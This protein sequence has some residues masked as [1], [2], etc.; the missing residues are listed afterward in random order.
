MVYTIG[1][2]CQ[3]EE[4]QKFPQG[5]AIGTATS[6]YQI[7]GA[8][9]ISDKGEN[10]W[11]HFTH[12]VDSIVH[13][14]STGDVAC[15]SYNLYKEDVK[16][17]K[18]IG[19]DFYR[20]SISWGRILPN[21]FPN[22]VS[23]EGL[24]YYH[25]LLDELIAKGI[26]PYVTLYHWD[27]PQT[28][29]KLGGWTNELMVQWFTDYARIV[30]RELGPKIKIFYTVNEPY[31]FCGYGYGST[32]LAPGTNM[33][34][35]ASYLCGHNVLKAH[36]SA[37]HLYNEEF[38][39][40]Q[41]GT[42]GIVNI[43]NSYISKTNDTKLE[44]DAFQFTCGWFSHP[45]FSKT[46]DYPSVM[47]KLVKED[48]LRNGWPKSRLPV[49]SKKW[50]KF[51]KGTSDF[52]GLNHYTS[53]MIEPGISNETNLLHDFNAIVSSDPKWPRAK[54]F[55]LAV[56]PEGFRM[57][58]LRLKKEYGNIAIH[59]TENGYSDHG[60][61]W[62][63][64]RVE[65]YYS[66]LKEMLKAIHLDGCNVQSYTAWS[67]LDN[68]EWASGYSDRFGLV[69]VDFDKPS[70][71]RTLKYSAKWFKSLLKVRKLSMEY[72]KS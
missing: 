60:V 4:D 30:F 68:F 22:Y 55:W 71:E 46:G 12:R 31:M 24:K 23:K 9:N 59:I 64:N 62:D 8:W 27:H 13:N 40:K 45:I 6:S 41:K 19:F 15:N 3:E 47:K 16:I 5:F 17:I 32:L 29:E 67:L 34:G 49:F 50:I 52:F 21:G 2:K 28:L 11:D 37:Y 48:S 18:N 26:K 35:I 14:K 72:N 42:I 54:S 66:Y 7:E 61:L 39:K 20:F 36:A 10:V 1:I 56:V 69:H 53:Q 25:N 65:F 43:C 58:L 57:I 38:R 63:E 33:S 44:N 51:I 70:R